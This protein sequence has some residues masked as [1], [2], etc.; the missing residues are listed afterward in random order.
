MSLCLIKLIIDN[1]VNTIW[2]TPYTVTH[3][4]T[5]V[6]GKRIYDTELFNTMVRWKWKKLIRLWCTAA[7]FETNWVQDRCLNHF[8]SPHCHHLRQPCLF[9]FFHSSL[10]QSVLQH[11]TGYPRKNWNWLLWNIRLDSGLGLGLIRSQLGAYY[12][13]H[14]SIDLLIHT[15]PTPYGIDSSGLSSEDARPPPWSSLD[16]ALGLLRILLFFLFLMDCASAPPVTY[17]LKINACAPF[18]ALVRNKKYMSCRKP[19]SLRCGR[20]AQEIS[21]QIRNISN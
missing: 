6:D 4:M 20:P 12:L 17:I 2:L 13:S 14:Y 1:D 16:F 21:V 9:I 10:L 5:L 15:Y 18:T 11:C 8:T 19:L 7:C 3:D